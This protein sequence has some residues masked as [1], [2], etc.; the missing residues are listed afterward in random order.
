MSEIS[1]RS[2]AAFLTAKPGNYILSQPAVSVQHHLR[3]TKTACNSMMK[4][5]FKAAIGNIEA[6]RSSSQ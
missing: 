1:L 2:E 3:R 6:K 4:K 5:G